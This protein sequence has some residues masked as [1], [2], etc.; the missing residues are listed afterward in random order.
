MQAL[1]W[2]SY[3]P[4]RQFTGMPPTCSVCTGVILGATAKTVRECLAPVQIKAVIPILQAA[5]VKRAFAG[6]VF[7]YMETGHDQPQ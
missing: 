6:L 4:I 5:T 3:I 2:L 1:Y 7:A